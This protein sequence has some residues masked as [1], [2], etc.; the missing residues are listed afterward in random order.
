MHDVSP[1]SRPICP[2][3]GDGHFHR[4]RQRGVLERLLLRILRLR[5]YRCSLCATRFYAPRFDQAGSS[6]GQ[7]GDGAPQSTGPDLK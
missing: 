6:G 3:C 2:Y 4:S 1:S 7:L 5:P